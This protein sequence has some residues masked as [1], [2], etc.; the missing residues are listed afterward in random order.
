MTTIHKRAVAKSFRERAIDNE[1]REIYSV[2]RG[3]RILQPDISKT[4]CRL[5]FADYYIYEHLHTTH[6]GELSP[7]N[8]GV[9]K[10]FSSCS[11]SSRCWS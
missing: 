6:F 8:V 10:V 3:R 5:W 2:E 4:I 9:V 11:S 1:S 7:A